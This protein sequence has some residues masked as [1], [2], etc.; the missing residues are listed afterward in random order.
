MET[1][2]IEKF[3]NEWVQARTNGSTPDNLVLDGELPF[4]NPQLCLDVI[5]KVLE[6]IDS[7]PENELFT[8]LAAGP[9]EDL[10]TEHGE[11]VV[12]KVEILARR[13]PEFRN[14]LNGVWDYD[15]NESIKS[16]LSKYMEKRW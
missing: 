3:A 4:N 14:L 6:K 7:K 9:L 1:D 15:I 10:L 16:K 2:E 13:S 11:A 8:I 12:G 5:I